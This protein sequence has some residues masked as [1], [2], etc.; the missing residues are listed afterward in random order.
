MNG[1]SGLV[2]VLLFFVYTYGLGYA[3]TR[4]LKVLSF[5]AIVMRVGIGLG[6]IPVLGV[7]LNLLGLPLHWSIFLLLS[8]VFPVADYIRDFRKPCGSVPADLK[9]TKRIVCLIVIFFCCVVMYCGGAFTYPWL[10]D[11]DSWNHA[12]SIKY[13]AMEENLNVPSG[14]FQYINPYPPGYDLVIALLHQT[15]PS[16]YWTLKFFN[17]L[18][19]ALGVLFFYFFVSVFRKKP[20]QALWATF[21]LACIPCYLSHF[22][23]S[24]SLVVTLFIVAFYCVLKSREDNRFFIAAAVVTAGIFLTQPTQPLKFMIMLCLLYG[25]ILLVKK[26]LPVKL[27]FIPLLA[28]V[29]SLSWYFPVCLRYQSGDIKI[30]GTIG[31]RTLTGQRDINTL[32]KQLFDPTAGATT[33]K[34]PLSTYLFPPLYNDCNSP[35]G[36]GFIIFILA[37]LGLAR[38]LA[39]LFTGDEHDKIYSLTALS[40]FSFTFLGLNSMTFSLPVGLFAY[41]FWPLLA[42]PVCVFAAEAA[43]MVTSRDNQYNKGKAGVLIVA[44]LVSSAYPKF[45]VNND[46]WE[47]GIS[48]ESV[49]EIKGFIWM[50]RHLKPDTKVFSFNTNKAVIGFDMVTP[51]WTKSYQDAFQEAAFLSLEELYARLTVNSYEYIIISEQ[52]IEKFGKKYMLEKVAELEASDLFALIHNEPGAFWLFKINR[53]A[54]GG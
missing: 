24:H 1:F 7:L 21:F 6:A 35:R 47:Y 17:G 38:G 19:V 28:V 15:S 23:W 31:S 14:I 40:W 5:E 53:R 13:I 4:F 52:T 43:Q 34:Y 9:V 48:W 27:L 2:T 33:Q 8:M 11:D 54:A 42:V 51:Y 22:I 29:L 10:E 37:V 45:F 44:V 39:A 25:S 30:K 20:S 26:R 36:F 49:Y 32:S 3:L 16:L 50:R 18:I 41:R 46:I 12:A